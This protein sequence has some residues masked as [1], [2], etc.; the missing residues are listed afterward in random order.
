MGAFQILKTNPDYVIRV[1]SVGL[2]D[3]KLTTQ[4]LCYNLELHSLIRGER[5]SDDPGQ[6]S[7]ST[8]TYF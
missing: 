2:Q 5:T 4:S 8:L 6:D 3:D 1:M 7:S